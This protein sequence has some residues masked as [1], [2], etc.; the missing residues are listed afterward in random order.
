MA[1]AER[2][3]PQLSTGTAEVQN[4][5]SRETLKLPMAPKHT[6]PLL[7]LE[8]KLLLYTASLVP[9]GAV[10]PQEGVGAGLQIQIEP[11][12]RKQLPQN[13][14]LSLLPHKKIQE[15]EVL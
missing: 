15:Q 10:T 4:I 2:L 1:A 5:G 7:L 3:E 11:A 12:A 8:E 9:L 13:L 14:N 6:M